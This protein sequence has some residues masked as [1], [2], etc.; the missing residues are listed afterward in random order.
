MFELDGTLYEVKYNMRTLEA[1][2][3]AMGEGIM[4][5]MMKSEGALSISQLRQLFTQ[6]LYKDDGGKV[7]PVQGNG[8]FEQIL[9]RDGLASVM[10][11]VLER[12]MDDCA[13]LFRG[14]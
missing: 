7:S 8:I 4:A 14:A 10:N 9:E 2:E 6:A 1:I 11:T 5:V 3:R 13:F 12:I